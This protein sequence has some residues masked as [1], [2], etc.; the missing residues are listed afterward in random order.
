MAKVAIVGAGSIVFCKTLILD[1]LA[2][3]GLE[4]IVR[5]RSQGNPLRG[6]E[7]KEAWVQ[8]GLFLS[9][10]ALQVLPQAPCA[11]PF[12][13]V[14]TVARIGRGLDDPLGDQTG[15]VRVFLN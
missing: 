7:R 9:P 1:I 14:S 8:A 4:D 5:T 12:A 11:G 2:T 6:M 3:E 10:R 15:Q 13:Q